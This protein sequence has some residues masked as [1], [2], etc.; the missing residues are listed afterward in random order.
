[1]SQYSPTSLPPKARRS[2]QPLENSEKFPP[3]WI[4]FITH[5]LCLSNVCLGY[6]YSRETLK[7]AENLFWVVG[8]TQSLYGSDLIGYGV[9][10]PSILV[11]DTSTNRMSYFFSHTYLSKAYREAF[12]INGL[13]W[14]DSDLEAAKYWFAT[15]KK[16]C[17]Y[18][19]HKL[20]PG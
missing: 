19:H 5:R 11:I 4:Q 12:K 8:W 16:Y 1:M 6:S 7:R 10:F 2:F 9:F 13:K 18:S 14:A 20:F 15:I 17:Q 3:K